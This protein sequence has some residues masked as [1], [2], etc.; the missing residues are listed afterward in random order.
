M[1][2]GQFSAVL[3]DLDVLL[4]GRG[5]SGTS[6]GQLLERFI[7]RRDELA[8][9]ALVA[10][11][12]PMVLAVCRQL[13]RDPNDVDDAFQATFL[14]LAQGGDAP[15]P[16]V[17]GPLALSGSRTGWRCGGAQLAA[18]RRTGKRTASRRSRR[19]G[20][21]RAWLHEEIARA[22]PRSIESRSC[23]ATSTA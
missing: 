3:R 7:V 15:R 21:A 20:R 5:V 11:H 16:G 6:E 22:C 13:L 18:Q 14:V 10:R 12:G 19:A 1:A 9:E 17:A 23:F 8:F 4:Q 2:T